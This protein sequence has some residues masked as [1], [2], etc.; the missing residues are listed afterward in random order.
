[1]QARNLL[2]WPLIHSA[3]K[4]PL[5]LNTVRTF[6]FMLF[7]SAVYFGLTYPYS[8][9]N[10]YTAAVFWSLFWP[11]FLIVSMVTLG[12]VFCTVCPHSFIGKYLNKIGPKKLMP[13]WMRHRSWGL[14][15]LVLSYWVPLYV[16]PEL[17]KMP[18][19]SALYF[20][21]LTVLA[22]AGFYLYRNMDYCRYGCPIGSVVKS[23]GKVD[24]ARLETKQSDCAQCR[25]YDCVKAC[26]W[27]L[28]PFQF[29]AKNSMQ[30]C[31]LCMDCVQ[32][33]DSVEWRLGR[34]AKQVSDPIHSPERMTVWVYITL[35]AVITMAM[36]FHHALGHSALKPDLP[37]VQAGQ[38]LAGVMPKIPMM[39]WVGLV[40]LVMA[41]VMTFGLTLGGLGLASRGSKVPFWSLFETAGMAFGVLMLVGALSHVGSFFF[42]HYAPNLAEA[43]FWLLGESRDVAPLASHRDGWIHWFTLFQFLAVLLSARI[44]YHKLKVFRLSTGR[45][46]LAYS[47]SGFIIWVYLGL[48]LLTLWARM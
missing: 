8:D 15:L 27:K 24:F 29:E 31:T 41:T 10:P 16:F 2:S 11:F 20:L 45:F 18:W 19:V 42:I 34:F 22:F 48:L 37:W 32:A 14:G 4:R 3:L 33:C 36:R 7:A 6:V 23:F 46:W 25:T 21:L 9:E 17:M 1:M 40:A 28:R 43:Y 30:D 12:P 13:N 39:D 47:V 26:Q 44:L 38:W 35:L 5:I